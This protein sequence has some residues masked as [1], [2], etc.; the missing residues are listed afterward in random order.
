MSMKKIETHKKSLIKVDGLEFK[1]LNGNGILDR[2]E[3]WRLPVE[4]RVAD[5][6]GKMTTEEKAGLMMID[7]LNA[8]FEGKLPDTA[9]IYIGKEH[10]RRFIFRNAVTGE[11][12]WKEIRHPMMSQDITARE[13]AHFT[14]SVQELCE[15]SRLGIPA[16]FKSNARNHYDSDPRFGINEAAGSFSTWPKEA[17]LASLQDMKVIEK[18]ASIMKQEWSAIGLRGMYGYMLDLATEPR[19]NR[20]HETFSENAELVSRIGETLIRT[21]QGEKVD[22]ESIVLTMKHFPG[23]GPQLEGFDPHY[24]Y[25]REQSYTGGAFYEH[26]KPFRR[27]IDA[28]LTSVMPYYGIPLGMQERYK[29]AEDVDYDPEVGVGMAFN[30]GIVDG[31]LRKELGF[32]GNVNSDTGIIGVRSWGLED[33]TEP[34][35]FAIAV[36]AGADVLSGYHNVET[37]LEVVG[38]DEI[39]SEKNNHRPHGISMERLDEASTRLLTELFELGLFENPY[40]DE[41]EAEK[42]VGREDFKKEA[43]E[44]MKKS[45][46]LLENNGVL[47]L[48]SDDNVYLLGLEREAAEKAGMK[49][50]EDLRKAEKAIVRVEIVNVMQKA[51]KKDGTPYLYPDGTDV[52]TMFGGPVPTEINRMS[53]TSMQYATSWK[54]TP[55]LDEIRKVMEAVGAN[56]T[57][58][59]INFRQPYVIDE[60]SGVRNAGALLATFGVNDDAFAE[61]A[62]GKTGPEGKLP[63]ALAENVDAIIEKDADVAGYGDDTLYPFGYGLTY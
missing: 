6:L 12:K 33:Y 24:P 21:L 39:T 8:E 34:Q 14:N 57:V 27:A 10:M 54:M 52:I 55:S 35:L 17:G 2:Y 19:W 63:Y 13:A 25:G 51:M 16:L 61:V 53:L 4:E 58:I 62:M 18:F 49:V 37:V 7:T 31:L 59:S 41:M 30:K 60:A 15:E 38:K 1:D 40:V 11:P 43:F 9:S 36:N 46:V 32:K 44:T 50:T 48:K 23:G 20:I 26:V 22:D 5:L 28:G 47:P 3:D 29:P 45:T 56:N 42:I